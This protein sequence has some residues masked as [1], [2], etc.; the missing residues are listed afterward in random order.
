MS[1]K[2]A[3]WSFFHKNFRNFPSPVQVILK[4]KMIKFSFMLAR[5]FGM[6][7]GLALDF[8]SLK[9]QRLVLRTCWHA[10]LTNPWTTNFESFLLVPLKLIG[11][12][13]TSDNFKNMSHM[14]GFA[15]SY[16]NDLKYH[17][18][19]LFYTNRYQFLPDRWIAWVPSRKPQMLFQENFC[20]TNWSFIR[21]SRFSTMG[22]KHFFCFPL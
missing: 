15:L 12:S 5:N 17:V 19:C 11:V 9:R 16:T 20:L 1:Y 14:A 7:L 2:Y 6:A 18:S 10:H 3:I 13:L 4:N 22:D 21:D 8:I